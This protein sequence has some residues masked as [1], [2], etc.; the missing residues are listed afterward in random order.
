MSEFFAGLLMHSNK[1]VWKRNGVYE[2]KLNYRQKILLDLFCR[3]MIISA[4]YVVILGG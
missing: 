2:M 1:Q 4:F 3:V